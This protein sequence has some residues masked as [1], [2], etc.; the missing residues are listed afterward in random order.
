MSIFAELKRRNVI[1]VA[2][3]YVITAWLILQVADVVLG[4]ID[5]PGRAFRTI[6][7]VLVLGFPR[8]MLFAWRGQPDTAVTWLERAYDARD[9]GIASVK[10]DP[11]MQSLRDHPGFIAIREKMNLAD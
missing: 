8:A 11:S 10:P 2:V 4:N 7:L 9:P 3:A 6:L 1:R 5:A